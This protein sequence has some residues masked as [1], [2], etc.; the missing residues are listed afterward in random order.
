MKKVTLQHFKVKSSSEAHLS[1]DLKK[2]S[3]VIL[4]KNQKP[5]WKMQKKLDKIVANKDEEN[6]HLKEHS[7]HSIA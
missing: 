1:E 4:H 7:Q 6:S 3:D 2:E 5:L